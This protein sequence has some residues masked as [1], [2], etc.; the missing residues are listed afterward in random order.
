MVKGFFIARVLFGGCCTGEEIASLR[1]NQWKLAEKGN[2]TMLIW[3]G[4]NYHHPPRKTK[5]AI[6]WLKRNAR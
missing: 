5:N 6:Q 2:A 3:P 1:R 4:K